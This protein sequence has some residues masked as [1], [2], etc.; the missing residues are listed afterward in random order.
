MSPKRRIDQG[1]SEFERA[2]LVDELCCWA[3]SLP[4]VVEWPA[5]PGDSRCLT[6]DCPPLDRRRVWLVVCPSA[7]VDDDPDLQVV[8]PWSIGHR[9]V[10]VG[11]GVL[12][13]ELDED[14]M[15]VGV[16][17]PTTIAELQALEALAQVAYEAAF[18]PS[19]SESR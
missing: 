10:A 15:L 1:P 6:V 18:A 11:W 19:E 3:R 8:L 13:T 2:S 14:R 9:G 16:A 5:E 17:A 4:W 7:G 12:I